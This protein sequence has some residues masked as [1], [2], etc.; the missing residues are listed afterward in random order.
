MRNSIAI[1]IHRHEKGVIDYSVDA[2]K[3]LIVVFIH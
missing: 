3:M 1:L 2:A